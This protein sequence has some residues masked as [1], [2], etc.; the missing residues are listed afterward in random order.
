[1]DGMHSEQGA[2]QDGGSEDS[3]SRSEREDD[4]NHG[5][6]LTLTQRSVR[7]DAAPSPSSPPHAWQSVP[8]VLNSPSSSQSTILLSQNAELEARASST[9]LRP[10]QTPSLAAPAS[11]SSSVSSSLSVDPPCTD[12]AV[13]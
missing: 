12:E 9:S 11:V 10:V 13:M 1:M 6:V 3:Y 8:S 7:S 5:F 2:T 4:G